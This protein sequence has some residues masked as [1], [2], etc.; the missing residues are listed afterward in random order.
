MIRHSFILLSGILILTLGIIIIR[1]IIN[2]LLKIEMEKFE[3][4]ELRRRIMGCKENEMLHSD[5]HK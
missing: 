1:A 3:M 5:S 4:I 2:N